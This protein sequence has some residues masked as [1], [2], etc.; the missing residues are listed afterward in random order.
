MIALLLA[1]ALAQ[2]AP[3][4]AGWGVPVHAP[5]VPMIWVP[6]DQTRSMK[7]AVEAAR[8]ALRAN[9]GEMEL[10]SPWARGTKLMNA[11]G[12]VRRELPTWIHPETGET[13]VRRRPSLGVRIT[14]VSVGGVILYAAGAGLVTA[15]SN[16]MRW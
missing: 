6:V 8:G 3:D 15:G 7:P 11:D 10:P 1:V 9:A 12:E 14:I 16:S 2:E 13:L 5:A 4:D